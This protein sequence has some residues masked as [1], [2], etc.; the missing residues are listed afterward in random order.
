MELCSK[1]VNLT[2]TVLVWGTSV[3]IAEKRGGRI[4]KLT[5]F[6]ESFLLALSI[7][8]TLGVTQ[9]W[10]RVQHRACYSVFFLSFFLVLSLVFSIALSHSFFF[11]SFGNKRE[12]WTHFHSLFST[13]L[14]HSE[15]EITNVTARVLIILGR[16]LELLNFNTGYPY[17]SVQ[18]LGCHLN[19]Q[20]R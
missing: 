19:F 17:C 6:Q 20:K 2:C 15:F 5:P 7:K 10:M 16:R 8:F 18:K 4:W 9:K 1:E 11:S 13:C 14:S 12:R 3:T